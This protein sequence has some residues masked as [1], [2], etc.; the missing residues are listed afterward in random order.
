MKRN[1]RRTFVNN[2]APEVELKSDDFSDNLAEFI[3]HLKYLERSDYTIE[4]YRREL[5]KFMHT[6]EDMRFKTDLRA[7]KGDLIE[8]GY[9]RGMNDEVGV[10]EG[11][12]DTTQRA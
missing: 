12:I 1:R 2:N 3:A 6:L 4:Y 10:E 9:G 7:I 5:R 11:R 8:G